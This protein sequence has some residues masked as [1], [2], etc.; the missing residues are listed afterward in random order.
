M[1]LRELV[2]ASE[3]VAATRS[4]N[5]KVERL[6]ACLTGLAPDEIALGVAALSGELPERLGVGPAA[7][8]EA[9]RSPASTEAT[10][11]LAELERTLAEIGA[12]TG[13]GSAR[14][15]AN[16]LGGLFARA[17]AAE[18]AFLAQ[19]ALGGLRQGAAAGLV[20][21]AVARAGS[22]SV[23]S[24]RHA[25]AVSGDLGAVA[26]AALTGGAPALDAFRLTLFQPLLPMLAQPADDLRL[27]L[28]A[29]GEAAL[30]WK[31]D[32][33][34]VQAH[35]QGEVVRVFT[36][37]LNEVSDALP[38]LVEAVRAL[39]ARSLVLDGE[40]IA[41]RRDGR[42]E[43]FQVT[44]RRF[45]RRLDVERLR[46][47]LPLSGFF[48]DCLHLDGDDLIARPT[49]ERFA[50][51]AGVVPEAQRV[52]RL[53]S[54]DPEAAESFLDAAL[55]AGHEGLMAKSLGAPY[56]AGGRG[57]AWRKLKTAHTLD[58]VVLAAEWGSGRRRGWLSN[59]H[60]GARDP[61]TGGFAMLGKTF[62]GLT[63]EVLA[64][65]TRE[66]LAREVA[67]DAY[68]VYVRP[69]LVVEIALSGVQTSPHY[70]A[71]MALRFARVRRYRP[72]KRAED[73]DALEAVRALH[74][75]E[76]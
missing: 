21:E 60:L 44:M 10:L 42:P 68:T 4:R 48:F 16:L 22:V 28:E 76:G 18:Q 19:L 41:L 66:L 55:A 9:S 65:Q 51:L 49:A 73:A 43:P 7:L 8:T 71:G 6:A 33:A 24:V 74:R 25:L 52:P 15:R 50:A 35:K 59:L 37:R 5:A 11:T 13:P 23:D 56:D 14:E 64:W 12:R 63:D 61:A 70:P 62:K 46:S 36:R 47:E 58:L 32:G 53:V 2:A 40:A 1:L 54:A 45:G 72:D 38:E 3:A 39:P 67:R 75:A 17:T 31:L 26:R 29:L 34:R 30:E 27:A 69:E 57:G 20:V